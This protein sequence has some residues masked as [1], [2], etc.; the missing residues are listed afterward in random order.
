MGAPRDLG[1]RGADFTPSGPADARFAERLSDLLAEHDDALA[2]CIRRRRGDRLVPAA[3]PPSSSTKPRGRSSIRCSSAR[4]SR[5]AGCRCV[6]RRASSSCCLRGEAT[7]MARIGDRLQ[8][9]TRCGGEKIAYVRMFSGTVRTRDRLRFGKDGEQ[10][11]TRICVFDRGSDGAEGFRLPPVR[12]RRSGVSATSRSVMPSA[13]HERP[14]S[15]TTSHRR[16]WRRSSS[17]PRGREGSAP[18]RA[19]AARGAGSADQPPSR[20]RAPGAVRLALRRGAERSHRGHAG[21]RLRPRRR[22]P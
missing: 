18:C 10:K 16:H 15:G 11:V 3:P 17:A 1:T 4:R 8:D 7:S 19:R 2:G 21:R 13:R 14:P 9:R 22:V 20:R 12:S 5:A 6:D